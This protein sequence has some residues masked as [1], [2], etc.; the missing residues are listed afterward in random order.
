VSTLN[1]PSRPSLQYLRKHGKERLADLRRTNP[2][3]QLAT[4]LLAIAQEYGFPSWRALKAEIDRRSATTVDRFIRACRQGD[5]DTVRSLLREDPTLIHAREDGHHATGL[6]FAAGHRETVQVLLDAGADPNLTD[7][8]QELGVI[9]W[10]T[11]FPEAIP[12]D[13][14]SLLIERGARHHI[15]SAIALGDPNVIRK[16]VEEDPNALDRRMS[17]LDHRQTAL[18]FAIGRGRHDMLDLLIELG[19]DVDATDS[20]GQTPLE[21]AMLRGDDAASARLRVAG[22]ATSNRHH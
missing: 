21:Y 2:D 8:V 14:V 12:S 3:A 11:C 20:A 6:F 19:A 4:A 22:P 9:G 1:L 5:T 17:R 13:A 15:F 10:A 16:L 18:H 7:D